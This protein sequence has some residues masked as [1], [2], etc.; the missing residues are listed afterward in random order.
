MRN[1]NA[2]INRLR[3]K[4]KEKKK[5]MSG[6]SMKWQDR[7]DKVEEDLAKAN[8]RAYLAKKRSRDLMQVQLCRSQGKSLACMLM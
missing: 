3:L 2:E 4:L 5:E 7:L 6:E 8:D 1:S